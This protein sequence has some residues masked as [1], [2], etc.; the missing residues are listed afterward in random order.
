MISPIFMSCGKKTELFLRSLWGFAVLSL[1]PGAPPSGCWFQSCV[2]EYSWL[3]LIWG[4]LAYPHLSAWG[5]THRGKRPGLYTGVEHC[6]KGPQHQSCRWTL[7]V[8]WAKSHAECLSWVFRCF[9]R[10]KRTK[11]RKKTKYTILDNMDE[12]ER[13]E[14]RPKYGKPISWYLWTPYVGIGQNITLGE[15]E[16]KVESTI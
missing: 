12:Q 9:F 10:R 15:M 6:L 14:L 1:L 4:K 7:L 16:T 2:S 3:A 11:I 5:I 8:R 13:M